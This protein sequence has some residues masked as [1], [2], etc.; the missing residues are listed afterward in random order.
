MRKRN[1]IVLESRKR[2]DAEKSLPWVR[3]RR[4]TPYPMP[5]KI[6]GQGQDNSTLPQVVM[7]SVSFQPQRPERRNVDV[8]PK[9]SVNLNVDKDMPPLPLVPRAARA[10]QSRPNIFVRGPSPVE[11]VQRGKGEGTK[12]R[13]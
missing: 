11:V 8:T 7:P 5:V 2:A 3:G 10:S 13:P 6:M 1:T 4:V 9:P 12:V